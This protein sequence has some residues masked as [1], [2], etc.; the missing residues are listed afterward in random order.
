MTGAPGKSFTSEPCLVA[1][2]IDF[3]SYADD[4]ALA[5]LSEEFGV[6]VNS[7][8]VLEVSP[9][10]RVFALWVSRGETA[11]KALWQER[12][13]AVIERMNDLPAVRNCI[14][15]QESLYFINSAGGLL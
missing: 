11:D 10:E 14:M 13:R 1:A 9:Y 12:I 8:E 15:Q 5:E 3:V 6:A 4:E 7:I 2:H